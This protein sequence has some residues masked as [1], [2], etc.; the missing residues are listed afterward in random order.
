MSKRP[1]VGV[2]PTDSPL[3]SNPPSGFSYISPDMFGSMC[4]WSPQIEGSPKA[5]L[6]KAIVDD[7]TISNWTSLKTTGDSIKRYAGTPENMLMI[8]GLYKSAFGR[9]INRPMHPKWD[10][11]HGIGGL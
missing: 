8:R 2:P 10:L 3:T 4:D 7:T 1:R 9:Y 6:A 5:I 11:H